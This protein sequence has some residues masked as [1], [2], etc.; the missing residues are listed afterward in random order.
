MYMETQV[1]FSQKTC[2]TLFWSSV[3]AKSFFDGFQHHHPYHL[4]AG[5]KLVAFRVTKE[6]KIVGFNMKLFSSQKFSRKTQRDAF[7]CFRDAGSTTME[8]PDFAVDALE[9]LTG[10]VVDILSNV[11]TKREVEEYQ[12]AVDRKV[13]AM[14]ETIQGTLETVMESMRKQHEDMAHQISDLH[15]FCGEELAKH[16]ASVCEAVAEEVGKFKRSLL[17][18]PR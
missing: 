1:T 8:D 6:N 18:V 12:E 13:D 10:T 3:K 7:S 11:P 17:S 5:N 2:A 16:A 9:D 4:T 15:K 14:R